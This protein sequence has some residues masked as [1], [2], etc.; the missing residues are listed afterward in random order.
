MLLAEK[1]DYLV[2]KKKEERVEINE[3]MKGLLE[4]TKQLEEVRAEGDL[5]VYRRIE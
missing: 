1:A 5:F 2:A 3:R 4:A